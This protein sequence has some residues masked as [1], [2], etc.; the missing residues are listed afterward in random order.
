MRN[1]GIVIKIGSTIMI[2]F[3]IVLLPL[4]IVIDRI[5]IQIYSTEVHQNVNNLSRKVTEYI[6]DSPDTAVGF[7]NHTRLITGKQIVVFNEMGIITS[8]DVFEYTQN[9]FI[10][11]N[12]FKIMKEGK[13]FEREYVNSEDGERFF[14]VGRPI[15]DG[16][17]FEG[18]ILVF[19][20]I[21]EIHQTMHD[22]RRWI[23]LSILVAIML[24]LGY[25]LFVSNRLSS[26]LIIMEKIT[27]S[28]AKGDLTSKV[29]VNSN[30]EVGSL[31]Q[32]I[33]DLS[34]ELNNFRTNRSELLA[35][36]SHELRT[37][38]SYLKGY[39]QLI[40]RHQYKDLEELETYSEI[41][42]KESE[43]LANLIQ[44]LFELSKME[45]GKIKLYLQSV[46]IEDVVQLAVQKVSLKAKNKGLVL[47]EEIKDDLPSVVSDGSRIEQIIL[48]LLE[49]AIYYTELGAITIK[50]SQI[51]E[52]IFISI[53]DTGAGIPEGDLPF[54]FDRFHRVE[55]SR[56]REMGGTGLGLAIVS[57]LI[58]QLNGKITVLSK[59]GVGSEFIVSLPLDLERSDS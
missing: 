53:K 5:F 2:L 11:K 56:S 42:E 57:Q 1:K 7:L 50:V 43:R 55:K 14:Y 33:N 23:F 37:P 19:S 51:K 21:D 8:K 18:G 15:I 47:L 30:D 3:L 54:I 34:M 39:A 24:A 26:P 46:D 4:G 49:N 22:V 10:D 9:E 41:I 40:N 52:Q 16:E 45:E 32:A 38:I 31:G 35:N 28:I 25:T 17:T 20:S 44:D 59:L 12:I 48:N 29:K 13:H 36:I 58:A 27:R 6:T